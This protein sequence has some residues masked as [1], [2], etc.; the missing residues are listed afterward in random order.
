MGGTYNVTLVN[1]VGCDSVATLN[2]TVKATSTSV[3]NESICPTHLPYS[4]NSNTYTLV[5]HTMLLY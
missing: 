4:W 3:T 1:S 5:E 2:L